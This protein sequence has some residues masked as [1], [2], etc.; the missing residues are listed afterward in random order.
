MLSSSVFLINGGRGSAE[1]EEILNNVQRV[2]LFCH[3]RVASET[4]IRG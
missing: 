1:R 4:N 2:S 3:D